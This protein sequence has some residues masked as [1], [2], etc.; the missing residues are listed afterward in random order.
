MAESAGLTRVPHHF[1]SKRTLFLTALAACLA[2]TGA[3]HAATFTVKDLGDDNHT[4]CG[5]DCTL[6]DA[7]LAANATPAADT[8]VFD[9]AGDL[10]LNSTLPFITSPVTIDG[11]TAPGFT[12]TPVVHVGA[13]SGD[14]S[15]IVVLS[16][17]VTIRSLAIAPTAVGGIYLGSPGGAVLE[18]N[19]ISAPS[20]ADGYTGVAAV[21]SS[22]NT[23]GG[24][25]AGSGNT[26]ER[27]GNGI[28]IL[29]RSSGNH[30]EGN[31]LRENIAGVWIQS[32]QNVVGGIDSGAGNAISASE[33]FGIVFAGNQATQNRVEGNL[34][35]SGDGSPD[36]GNGVWG[37]YVGG[38]RN[39]I[40]GAAAAARN[41]I[42]GNGWLSPMVQAQ[43]AGI[44]LDAKENVVVGNYIGTDTTGMIAVPNVDYG[45]WDYRG[46][47]TIG[48][49]SPGAGNLISG[50]QMGIDVIGPGETVAGNWIG[51]DATG[52]APLSNS[53]GLNAQSEITIGGTV[54]NA[55]NVISGNAVGILSQAFKVSVQGNYI[56][57]DATGT[58]AVPNTNTGVNITYGSFTIANNVISGNATGLSLGAKKTST[59]TGNYIGNDATGT[60]AI[61]N[62]T[63]IA[64][65]M[66]K[67]LTIGGTVA[68]SAN[69]I[70]GNTGT[71]LVVGTGGIVTLGNLIGTT[72]AGD[73][74]LGNAIGIDVTTP[75]GTTIGGTTPGAGN[76]VSG[77]TEVGIEVGALGPKPKPNRILGNWIGTNSA[78]TAAVPN[79]LGMHI[80]GIADLVRGNVVSGN[81]GAGMLLD[82]IGAVIDGNLVGVAADTT[83]LVGNG[84]DGIDVS[85]PG[86]MTIG[87]AKGPGNVIAG[88]TGAGISI[89][90]FRIDVVGNAIFGN[91][92][93]GID[94][95]GDGATANDPGDGDDGANHLQNYPVLGPPTL[96]KGKLIM[97]GTLDSPA[98]SYVVR[99]Y[100]NP[101]GDIPQG[102]T[103]LATAKIKLRSPGN[104]FSV[105]IPNRPAGTT[106]TATATD[107][108]GD[109]SEFSAAVT[110]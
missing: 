17:G 58:V 20:L 80:S 23:I 13:Y 24:T 5:A 67:G 82:G 101:P 50:N 74:P 47:N 15:E 107:S 55:R 69:V 77:N 105:T 93:L 11:S 102:R 75:Q 6:R 78:G 62:G 12:D 42:S 40:G 56:G 87:A 18:G 81:S 59:V 91:G 57:T 104:A 1:V 98:G 16:A 63:G 7:L 70:S 76:V 9:V 73:A 26:I 43:G 46:G 41:V 53:I 66:S 54:A 32:P 30:V 22:N 65:S 14:K 37:V 94:L 3:A 61:P 33:L 71:G 88:N 28:L 51:T 48:G 96:A 38:P 27:L 36:E 49:S 110:T 92:G 25:S 84:A 86:P 8:I 72:A 109:T 106:I 108:V 85:S 39:T 97:P 83:T 21:D 45:I 52:S 95:D 31:T 90:G 89:V 2:W 44:A 99:I 4:G 34:I 29:G 68:G 19:A 79:G 103:L 35:G 10:T 100:A 64:T 60:V